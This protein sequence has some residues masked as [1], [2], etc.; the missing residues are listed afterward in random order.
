MRVARV[1]SDRRRGQ[2]GEAVKVIQ[3]GEGLTG[4]LLGTVVQ[5]HGRVT[6]SVQLELVPV[7]GGQGG[8]G[9]GVVV[10]VSWLVMRDS[11]GVA[12]ARGA[13]GGVL[14]SSVAAAEV[15]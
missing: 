10:G 11:V 14:L 8:G 4:S 1:S 7:G 9:V 13:E 2:A 5:T 6:A 15:D 12:S 3:G